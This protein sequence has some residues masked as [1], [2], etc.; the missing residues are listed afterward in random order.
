[1]TAPTAHT[2]PTI[3]TH[4]PC[5]E[6]HL[7][8]RVTGEPDVTVLPSGD[9]LV[10]ARIAVP[11]PRPPAGRGNRPVSD[12]VTC[13][14]WAAEVRRRVR[15][16]CKDDVVE[17]RGALRRRFWKVD[18]GTRS[19]YVVEVSE[20]SLLRATMAAQADPEVGVSGSNA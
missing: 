8:G 16:W 13:T 2:A 7:I 18:G 14:A 6:V 19:R 4:E 9:E 5:N 17:V 10:T 3:F 15:A 1:M 20:V 11:R 12:S